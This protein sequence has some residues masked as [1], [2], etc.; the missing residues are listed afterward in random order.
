MKG[1]RHV[2]SVFKSLSHADDSAGTDAKAFFLGDFDCLDFHVVAVTC[3]D[4]GKVSTRSL[5]I[6]MIARN[7]R[8]SEPLELLPV[9]KTH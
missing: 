4:V 9:D 3:A 6:V 7:A 5:N 1:E 8:F 2:D